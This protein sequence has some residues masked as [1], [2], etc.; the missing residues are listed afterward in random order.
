MSA[1]SLAFGGRLSRRGFVR[2]RSAHLYFNTG[3]MTI[4]LG[5]I[6]RNGEVTGALST[7]GKVA[8]MY[9]YSKSKGL[10]GMSSNLFVP[11]S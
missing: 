11:V 2:E 4:A 7:E 3:N 6:G 10:F 9:C 5:P 8:A 1:G